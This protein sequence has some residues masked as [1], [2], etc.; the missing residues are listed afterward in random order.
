MIIRMKGSTTT[1]RA[2]NIVRTWA[3]ELTAK[4]QE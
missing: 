2:R 1:L 3:I 4:D